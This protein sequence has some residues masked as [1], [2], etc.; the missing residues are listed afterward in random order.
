MSLRE[1][2]LKPVYYSDQDNLLTNFYLPVLSNSIKYDRIAGYFCSNALA[3]A[4][5]G[6]C[7][8]ISNGGRI[9]L[10]AN[11]VLSTDDQ[12]AIKEAIFQKEREILSDIEGLEDQLKK[13]HIRMLGWLVRKDLLQIKIAVV[14]NGIE[15]QK[16]GILKDLVGNIISFSGSDNETVPGWLHND[17]QFHVFCSWKD[18]DKDH[19]DPD[20][21]RFDILWEDKGNKVRVFDASDAFKMGLIKNAPKDDEEFKRL[22]S[23]VM[24]DLLKEH[25]RYYDIREKEGNVN[26]RDYQSKAIKEWI[27]NNYKGI[28]EMATGTGKTYTSLFAVKKYIG[29]SQESIVLIVCCPLQHLVDQWEVSVKEIFPD[30]VIVKCYDNKQKWYDPLN[31]LFQSIIFRKQRFGVVITT[32]ATG[33]SDSFIKVVN[34]D[35]VSKIVIC[36]E[37]HNIG[38]EHS[39][40]FLNINAQARIGLSATPI[41]PYDEE[42]NKAIREYFGES[43]YKL[44]I[45]EAINMGFLVPYNY[46]VSF[47][48]LNEAEYDEYRKISIKIAQQYSGGKAIDEDRLQFLLGQ[49]AKIISTCSS[50]LT[51][52]KEILNKLTDHNNILVYTAEESDF[53]LDTLR[54]LKE[55][56]IQRTLKVTAEIDKEERRDII[57]KLE[58]KDIQCIL[59]MRCLD[60]GVDIPSAN[61]AIILA[62]ST[63][64]KQY[65]QRRGRVLRKDKEGKKKHADIYDFFVVPPS[66]DNQI[67]KALYERELK[68]VLEFA[69]TAKNYSVVSELI[70]F[71]RRNALMKNFTQLLEEFEI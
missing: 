24:E 71:S 22:S 43:I 38:S 39:K 58:N 8:F 27:D 47:C 14:K 4:A 57:K 49:R 52:L 65:I 42:G 29:T 31:S 44:G 9:R 26:I 45:K 36:D 23:H 56:N 41:R 61:K 19:L 55:S 3:I 32:T 59:A 2:N 13:D 17:E 35:K 37:V 6:I 54:V 10:I 60:E 7:N 18:G 50:K 21:G 15:H 34:T 48:N 64:T 63:N 16:M 20:I 30:T 67:D 25:S 11:V 69:S 28:F 53:F 62:S 5:K 12:E 1:L 33:S 66:F 68:R 51:K 40:K 46:F 70:E